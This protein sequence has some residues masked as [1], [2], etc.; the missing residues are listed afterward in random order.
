V[1]RTRH[2]RLALQEAH[3]RVLEAGTVAVAGGGASGGAGRAKRALASRRLR[4][5]SLLSA[6][7]RHF[8]GA[9][10]SH[11]GGEVHGHAMHALNA[12][13]R[14]RDDSYSSSS[15]GD[16]SN[17]SSSSGNPGA[18]RPRD[19]YELRDAFVAHAS[20]AHAACLLSPRDASLLRAVD[21]TLQLALDFRAAMRRSTPETLLTDA[22]LYA[23]AQG[24]H[25]RFTVAAREACARLRDA[26]RDVGGAL[27]GVD[28]RRA[29]A[30]LRQLDYN[31]YYLSSAE[32]A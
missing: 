7:L 12:R 17:S 19:L 25:A 5:L 1:L 27:G 29:A 30:L 18:V 6:E 9:V 13:L 15:G 4:R 20:D 3:A 22:P 31:G 8:V 28:P 16:G 2:A 11:V 26:A 21:R 32:V 10:E 14:A 23:A 24:V